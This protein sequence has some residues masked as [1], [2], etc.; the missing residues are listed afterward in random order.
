MVERV[1]EK[2]EVTGSCPVLGTKPRLTSEGKP[3]EVGLGYA[4]SMSHVVIPRAA[5]G[6][7]DSHCC[8]LWPTNLCVLQ[9]S[10]LVVREP[11]Y[12]PIPKH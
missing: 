7:M 10:H 5:P 11:I 3:R 2:H 9:R 1:S 4:V 8:T 6:R 12:P